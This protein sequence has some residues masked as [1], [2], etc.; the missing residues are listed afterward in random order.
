MLVLLSQGLLRAR[1]L[2]L[3]QK[4]LDL[5]LRQDQLPTLHQRPGLKSGKILYP[6]Q[7]GEIGHGFAATMM[8]LVRRA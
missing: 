7:F 8:S 2:T 4:R 3:V 6:H 5:F 1:R